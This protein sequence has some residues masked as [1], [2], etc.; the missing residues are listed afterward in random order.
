MR[1]TKKNIFGKV[2]FTSHIIFQQFLRKRRTTFSRLWM[3]HGKLSFGCSILELLHSEATFNKNYDLKKEWIFIL[4]LSKKKN[5]WMNFFHLSFEFFW[6]WEFFLTSAFHS[7]EVCN[8]D[9]KRFQIL[10]AISLHIQ[11]TSVE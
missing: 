10:L 5:L 1:Q 4:T 6:K 2:L 9:L 3:F 7:F 11:R 8:T